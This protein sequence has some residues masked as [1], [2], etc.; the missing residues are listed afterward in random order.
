LYESDRLDRRLPLY[1]KPCFLGS[2]QPITPSL[3]AAL[4]PQTGEIIGQTA[5]SCMTN[6]P[7]GRYDWLY[8]LIREDY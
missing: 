1:S 8:A 2:F 4:N 7:L 5:V 3:Y 6:A